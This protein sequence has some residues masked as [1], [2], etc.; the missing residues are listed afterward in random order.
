MTFGT[1][2]PVEVKSSDNRV[3]GGRDKNQVGDVFMG[4]FAG[5]RFSKGGKEIYVFIDET[6]NVETLIFR[7]LNLEEGLIEAGA[8]I[9]SR[10]AIQLSGRFTTTAQAKCGAG[11]IMV[12]YK[13]QCDPSFVANDELKQAISTLMGSTA[14]VVTAP[15]KPSGFGSFAAAPTASKPNPFGK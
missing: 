4:Y 11:K 6:D 8:K 10:V 1:F 3:F 5:S 14:P 9:G 7:V 13:V 2:A 12:Q 15:K